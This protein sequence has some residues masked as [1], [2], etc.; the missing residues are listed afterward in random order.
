MRLSLSINIVKVLVYTEPAL[1][2]KL[3]LS[4]ITYFGVYGYENILFFMVLK[5]WDFQ[6]F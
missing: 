5:E 3:L 4:T 2:T 1:L 6:N